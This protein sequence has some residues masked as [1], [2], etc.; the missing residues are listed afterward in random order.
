MSGSR[1]TRQSGFGSVG[2]FDATIRMSDS[3]VRKISY[4]AK[5]LCSALITPI[6]RASS[7][8]YRCSHCP[9]TP[10]GVRYVRMRW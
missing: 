5:F 10:F 6:T 9:K 4:D 8:S 7:I 3:A 1:N 2:L